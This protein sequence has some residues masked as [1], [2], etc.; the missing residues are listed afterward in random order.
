MLYYVCFFCILPD[1][2]LILTIVL[3]TLILTHSL[4]PSLII[5]GEVQGKPLMQISIPVQLWEPFQGE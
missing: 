5:L 3:E 4:W 2:G 1:L